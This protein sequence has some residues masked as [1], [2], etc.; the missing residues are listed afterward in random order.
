[1]KST[2]GSKRPGRQQQQQQ[3]GQSNSKAKL[4]VT[5]AACLPALKLGYSAAGFQLQ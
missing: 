4:T 1:M 5:D 3:Q 2:C